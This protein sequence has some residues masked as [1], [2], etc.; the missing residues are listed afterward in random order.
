M[1]VRLCKDAFVRNFGP[2]TYFYS[3]TR[4]SDVM[5]EDAYVFACAIT[6]VAKDYEQLLGEVLTAYE[7]E[8]R[9]RIDC[10]LRDFIAELTENGFAVVGECEDELNKKDIGFSYLVVSPHT[11]VDVQGRNVD[12]ADNN[13]H[14]KLHKYF[15]KH[16]T[17]FILHV[18]LTSECNERCV[19]CYVPRGRHFYITKECVYK[20]MSEFRKM[21]GLDITFSGGE[22]LLHPDF[23]DIVK[24]AREL[25]LSVTILSNLTM[26]T[27]EMARILKSMNLALV[28]TSLYSMDSSVHDSI[29]RLAGSHEKTRSAIELLH[30]L[31]VPV[32]IACPCMKTN[33]KGYREVLEYAYGLKV[34]AYT[35]F[36]MM[37]R[38]DGTSDNLEY[39][40]NIEE[41]ISLM[42]TIMENELEM[43]SLLKSK[44]VKVS[45]EKLAEYP[46]CGIGVDSICLN[47]DGNYYACSGFQ[48]CTLGNCA[49]QTL[50][51]VWFTSPQ[52]LKLRGL[53]KK[54]IPQCLHCPDSEF[55][56]M[57]LVRNFNETGN[58]LNVPKHFCEIAQNNHTLCDEYEKLYAE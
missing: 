36:I 26:L 41:S 45:P 24:K 34:K 4:M 19:H 9:S 20:V 8:D 22:C 13:A 57:C 7:G 21:E 16:P 31:D 10:D 42:R 55:C 47:A 29:T 46:M 56:S 52:I 33:F 18:D 5:Y 25:D 44:R 50:S 38:S 30:S 39:R 49:E 37:A 2:Y 35:D 6:R 51:E 54:D 58:M 28:Q 1:L 14:E 15:E 23:M 12:N 43:K 27:N 11:S 3:Q 53:R 40:L 32:Q 17:P 48:G